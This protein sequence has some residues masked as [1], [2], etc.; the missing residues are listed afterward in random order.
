VSDLLAHGARERHDLHG[1]ADQIVLAHRPACEPCFGHGR[2]DTLLN[3]G[4]GPTSRKLHQL[5]EVESGRIH[6]PAAEVNFEDCDPFALGRQVHEEHFVE[7]SLANHF[8]GEQVDSVGG[9]G[10]EQAR[11]FSCIQVRKNAKIRPCSPPESVVEVIP[12][13]ISSNQS[14]AGAM[15]SNN[16]ARLD[17][18]A[19]GLAMPPGEDLDHVDAIEREL[20]SGSNGFDGEALA[21][22]WDAHEED[23]LGT[24]SLVRLSRNRNSS[25]RS[26]AISSAPRGR[27]CP[28]WLPPSAMYSMT[29]LRLTRRRFSS[30]KIGRNSGPS[31]PLAEW[32]R[33]NAKRA[34]SSVSPSRA[35]AIDRVASSIGPDAQSHSLSLFPQ[36]LDQLDPVGRPKLQK[37]H[38]LLDF[39]RNE[40]TGEVM[41]TNFRW[42]RQ[43][44]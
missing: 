10:D 35:P 31:D 19:F 12:I 34:S 15:S 44:S 16:P 2:Y 42:S 33:R 28:R 21:A 5:S 27:R 23:P 43:L 32:T 22:A 29:P 9:G 6:T 14:T 26:A 3:L 36:H 37:H 4:S 20:E 17:E 40:P 18:C 13:S 1:G 7:T 39:L 38:A 11:A 41:T 24:I 25:R 8:R 30:S